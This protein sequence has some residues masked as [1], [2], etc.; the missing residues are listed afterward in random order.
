M[1]YET[2]EKC[3]GNYGEKQSG[4]ASRGIAGRGA[5]MLRLLE[6]YLWFL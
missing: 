5:K 3:F 6:M 4:T 2:L 1:S